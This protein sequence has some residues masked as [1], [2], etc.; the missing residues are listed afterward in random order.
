M[1]WRGTNPL[2][3]PLIVV[4]DPQ[5]ATLWHQA[6]ICEA[7]HPPVR[8]AQVWLPNDSIAYFLPA[9]ADEPGAF[10]ASEVA[11]EGHWRSS[12]AGDDVAPWPSPDLSWRGRSEFLAALD[13]VEA[14]TERIAYRGYS[15]CRLCD[16]QNGFEGL[17]RYRWEWPAGFR[18]YVADHGVRPS[19]EFETFILEQGG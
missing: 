15:R 9:T 14:A 7:G 3:E 17:V 5:N 13:R 6:S 12:E 8:F 10:D 4:P 2:Q 19:S 1:P 16:C 18:H 11:L